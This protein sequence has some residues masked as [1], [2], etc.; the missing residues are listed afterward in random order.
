MIKPKDAQVVLEAT[1]DILEGMGAEYYLDS[2]TL[3]GAFRDKGGFISYDHDV[4]LRVLPGQIQDS[5]MS[6]FVRK[7]WEAGFRVMIQNYGGRAELI[8]MHENTVMLDLKFAFKDQNLLWI[9]CWNQPYSIEAPRVH[10]YPVKFFK[11]LSSI[12]LAGRKYPCPDPVE[13]YIEYHYGKDW[14]EFKKR[15]EQADETDLSWDFMYSPP[16]AMS[17]EELAKKRHALEMAL[18]HV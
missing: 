9:Y 14:K 16:C 6:D 10:A 17:L 18:L 5:Q 11:V 13:G 4:D 12:E 2:G 8:C 1:A 7:L 3:L 15:P